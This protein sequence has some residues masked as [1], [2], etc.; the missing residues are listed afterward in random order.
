MDDPGRVAGQKVIPS[1]VEVRLRWTLPNSKTVYNVLHASRGGGFVASAALIDT[2]FQAVVAS[3]GWTSWK[4]K[5]NTTVSFAG[6]D[7]RDLRAANLPLAGSSAAASPGTGAG[8]A[9]PPG[10][11]LCLT[12]RTAGAG[13]GFR[14]RVY[15]PGLDFSGL[16]AGGV[17]A[18]ATNTA[19]I[20]FLTAVQTAMTAQGMTLGLA[21]P[22][23]QAYV[24]E[25][26]ASHPD[27][28]AAVVSV[29]S[30]EARNTVVDHQRR[31]AGRS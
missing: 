2:V 19:A 25:T 13:R 18:A 7:L 9:L 1:C 15:L 11:A 17:L 14:G 28:P 16:A 12:L 21:Q 10:D 22:H 29:T 27:R 8:G 26:G 23:R 24:G 4:A 31:R 30:I 3:A 6:M 5:L 20:S